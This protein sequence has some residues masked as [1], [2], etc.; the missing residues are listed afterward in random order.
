MLS[1]HV[2]SFK[3][4]D[5]NGN[6]KSISNSL[7]RDNISHHVCV[8]IALTYPRVQ[9]IAQ[10]AMSA[11]GWDQTIVAEFTLSLFFETNIILRFPKT[12]SVSSQ[13]VKLCSQIRITNCTWCKIQQRHCIRQKVT[14]H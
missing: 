11:N 14:K 10:P 2:M 9:L 6:N 3:A 13:Q 1:Y 4:F 12:S 5:I 8:L 7:A